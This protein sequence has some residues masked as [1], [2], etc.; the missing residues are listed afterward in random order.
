M[1]SS[2]IN[3]CAS[4]YVVFLHAILLVFAK[5]KDR[6]WKYTCCI[7]DVLAYQMKYICISEEIHL[8]ISDEIHLR[9]I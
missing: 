9:I 4:A 3:I 5:V 2:G 1:I 8:H 6:F 7:S